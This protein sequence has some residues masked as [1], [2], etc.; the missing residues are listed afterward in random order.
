AALLRD[1]VI[2]TA[3]RIFIVGTFAGSTRFGQTFIQPTGTS[4]GFFAKYSPDGVLYWART[5]GMDGGAAVNGISLADYGDLVVAGNVWRL[6][7]FSSTAARTASDRGNAFA[8]RLS[9]SF[10]TP[11]RFRNIR[12]DTNGYVHVFIE[13][14][15]IGASYVLEGSNDLK[16]WIPLFNS[17]PSD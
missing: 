9:P 14:G 1:V 13:G 12:R 4:D 17:L 7:P 10:D 3:D 2:D 8:A 6:N 16:T 5:A 11:A 15:V